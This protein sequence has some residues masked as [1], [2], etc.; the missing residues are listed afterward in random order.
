MQ[1]NREQTTSSLASSKI[2]VVDDEADITF[3]LKVVLEQSAFL[4][5]IFNDPKIAL[6]N[7]KTDLLRPYTSRYCN[8]T[9]ERF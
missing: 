5:D 9:N 2:M 8:A 7:F 3:T 4:L 1:S 6:I